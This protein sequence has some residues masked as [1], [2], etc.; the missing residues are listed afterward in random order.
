MPALCRDCDAVVAEEA[1]ACRACGGVRIVRHPELFSLAI[2]HLDCDAFYASVEKRDRPELTERPVIVGGGRRGVV[3]AACYVARRYGVR[4]AMPMF[5]ALALCPEA[6]VIR[7]EMAKYAE[8]GRAVRA[9][10]ERL[11]PLVQPLSIDEAV[12]DLSGTEALHHAPP[13]VTLARLAREVER[14]VRVTVSIG[15]A[16][17][18]M[19]AKMA[20]ERDKPRGFAVIGRADAAAV[21]APML[22]S[23]LPGVGPKAADRLAVKGFAT[24]GQLA[25][26]SPSEALRRLGEDGP[27]LAAMARGED[28]RPVDPSREAKSIS[29]ET[30]F[31]E[32]LSAVAELERA[33]WPLAERLS[34][35]LKAKELAAAGVT[36]KLKTASFQIRTRHARLPSPT[37]LADTL[38]AAARAMLARE[39][40]G[41]R[42]RLIG[43]GADPLAEAAEA[44]RGDL[45]DPAAPKRKA[46]DQ[47]MDRLREKFGAGVIGK[48]RGMG[49]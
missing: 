13:A 36:L 20:A 4:S 23:A 42:F 25:A 32:D 43:I 38:F 12:L 5:K 33:L 27:A 26:L 18:R 16:P 39:A 14:T 31:N 9:L 11:T 7:P 35:R 47:A 24:L 29:A 48:G 19:L 44:D 3:T 41:V 49:S 15:L 10:M 22:V 46:V 6:V 8:A 37:Q 45:A 17:N 21:L 28:G 34:A 2:A 30:T 40:T 1:T